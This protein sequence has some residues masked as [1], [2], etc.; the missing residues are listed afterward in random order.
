MN[1]LTLLKLSS[2]FTVPE[3]ISEPFWTFKSLQPTSM[4]KFKAYAADV[5]R[6]HEQILSI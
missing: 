1:D 6:T 3:D 5:K 4:F 2:I